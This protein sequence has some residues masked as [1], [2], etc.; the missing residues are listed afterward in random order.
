MQLLLFSN[1]H[2]TNYLLSNNIK[3]KSYNKY[4][5][6]N[7]IIFLIILLAFNFNLLNILFFSTIFIIGEIIIIRNFMLNR[8]NLVKFLFYQNFVLYASR[9]SIILV[10]ILLEKNILYN[11]LT[12]III[13]TVSIFY[14]LLRINLLSKRIELNHLFLIVLIFIISYGLSSFLPS[15]TLIYSFITYLTVVVANLYTFGY[16]RL[17][18]LYSIDS[19]KDNE[20]LNKNHLRIRNE[21]IDLLDNKDLIMNKYDDILVMIAY[22]LIV[23]KLYFW[24]LL[25]GIIDIILFIIVIYQDANRIITE[26]LFFQIV[27]VLMLIFIILAICLGLLLQ[28]QQKIFYVVINGKQKYLIED[29]QLKKASIQFEG[30]N[31]YFSGLDLCII[32]HFKCLTYPF[33]SNLFK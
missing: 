32:D 8:Q 13:V 11:L 7:F 29:N 4:F 31:K 10:S 21:F 14:P 19:N 5:Q 18:Y 20:E 3:L 22:N 12:F 28:K 17:V 1:L 24:F 6:F 27:F 16:N 9:L 25:F 2:L 26:K 30:H 33:N 15:E 23:V